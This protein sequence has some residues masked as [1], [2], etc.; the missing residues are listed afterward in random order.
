MFITHA[1]I[2][3]NRYKYRDL[4]GLLDPE[5][6]ITGISQRGYA[7]GT[8]YISSVMRIINQYDLTKYDK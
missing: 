4:V 3:S 8:T 5:E 2:D 1:R 7:T 6:M